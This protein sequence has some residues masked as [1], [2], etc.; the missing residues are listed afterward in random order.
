[1]RE[2]LR[3]LSQATAHLR[4]EY[5]SDD[6]RRGAENERRLDRGRPALAGPAPGWTV[7]ALPRGGALAGPVAAERL[8]APVVGGLPALAGGGAAPGGAPPQ[9]RSWTRIRDMNGG[10]YL[11]NEGIR[12]FMRRQH[13]QWPCFARHEQVWQAAGRDPLGMVSGLSLV[14]G[15]PQADPR[16]SREVEREIQAVAG[17]IR[18]NGVTIAADRVD[19]GQ[20]LGNYVTEVVL[21]TTDDKSF[22]L[23]REPAE[24]G[25]EGLHIY[26]WEGGTAI[27]RDGVG[28]AFLER[29][30]QAPA[31]PAPQA[32][33][34]PPPR[35][36]IAHDLAARHREVPAEA[37]RASKLRDLP[38]AASPSV[39][40]SSDR[41]SGLRSAG[42]LPGGSKE[43]PFLARPEED[44][45]VT[46][47][48]GEKGKQLA[49]SGSFRIQSLDQAGTVLDERMA[50]DPEDA[51]R[52]PP[53]GPRP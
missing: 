34:A 35:P 32:R 31:L 47:I 27:Y 18:A 49:K 6:L 37:G 13:R 40:A 5:G 20:A 29:T 45:T 42:F 26:C 25:F 3:L 28:R 11:H 15:L 36:P 50:D 17:W 33:L 2:K 1:M 14:R 39:T 12:A 9:V 53:A 7:P 44:G 24:N 10:A 30:A 23:V 4:D 19:H 41:L 43:G 48:F 51:L 8:P 38:T 16:E 22:L 21:A 46:R 52:M